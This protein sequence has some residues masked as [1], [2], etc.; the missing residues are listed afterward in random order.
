LIAK[1][2]EKGGVMEE[3]L[4]TGQEPELRGGEEE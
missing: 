4:S 1:L 3:E 2:E